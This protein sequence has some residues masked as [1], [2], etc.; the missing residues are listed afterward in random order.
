MAAEGPSFLAKYESLKRVRS[1]LKHDW[2]MRDEIWDYNDKISGRNLATELGVEVP[3]LLAPPQPLRQLRPVDADRF[4]LKP[5]NGASSNAVFLLR[6]R[7]ENVWELPDRRRLTWE[8]VLAEAATHVGSGDVSPTFFIEARVEGT[9]TGPGVPCDF[10]CY[11]FGGRVEMVMQKSP[12]SP[13]GVRRNRYKY[14]SRTWEDHGTIALNGDID[15]RLP[16][17]VHG[18]EIVEAAERIAH[19][20]PTV[21]VRVD[22]YDAVTGAVFGEVTPQPG[23]NE[24]FIPVHDRRLGEAWERAEAAAYAAE[25][26]ERRGDVRHLAPVVARPQR[27]TS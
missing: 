26:P 11:C 21:F 27:T 8:E 25:H 12:G 22:L 19:E 6:R 24:F 7:S 17:P 9:E 3:A 2:R 14:W 5:L 16:A 20:L 1:H 10:K 4:V 15:A 23:G 13:D 18:T